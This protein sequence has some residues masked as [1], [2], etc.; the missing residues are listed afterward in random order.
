MIILETDRFDI[1]R[2]RTYPH[3]ITE[4]H[5]YSVA[6]LISPNPQIFGYFEEVLMIRE[7]P[8]R[9]GSRKTLYFAEKYE[10]FS[11]WNEINNNFK[12]GK[13]LVNLAF[14]EDDLNYFK[15]KYFV[16]LL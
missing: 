14:T 11:F 5:I 7:Y 2:Y 4:K 10:D 13:S 12:I 1:D 15:R 8:K 16:V 3:D 9:E 6:S